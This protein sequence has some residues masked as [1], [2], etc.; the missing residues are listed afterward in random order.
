M[1]IRTQ[2][3]LSMLLF[4]VVLAGI[5]AS[6][7]VT[8]QRV[9]ESNE[10]ESLANNVAQGASE[11]SFL[12]NDYLIYR[13]D[14]QLGRWQNRFASFSADVAGL[15][16][17]QPE[18][19]SL[20]ADI[21]ANT[22]RLQ[23]VFD[24]VVNGAGATAQVQGG[25]VDLT[26]L[27]VSWSRLAVQSQGLISDASRLAQL[28]GA[29]ADQT[30][31]TNL[32]VIL[33]MIGLFGA[34][35]IVNYLLVQ[36][37]T[38]NSISALRAWSSVIGAGN[39]DLKIEEKKND[40]IG[41]LS[42]AFN[43]MT[44]SLKEVTASKAELE[45]EVAAR[46]ES[47]AKANALIKYAPT[48][49]YEI[50]YSGPRF[51]SVNDAVCSLTGFSREELFAMGP[52]ALLDEDSRKLFAERIRRQ[53]GGEQIDESVEY[54]IRKKDG[55]VILITLN[56]SFSKDKPHT[57]LV[58]G[59]DVTERRKV[60][61]AL[62]ESEEK[63]RQLYS[64]MNDGMA[65]HE[66]L[67]DEFGK[68]ID[69]RILDVNPMYE[70]ITGLSK[71]QAAGKK[72]TDLYGTK[73]P[74]YLEIYAATASSGSALS[75]ETYF[76]PMD[77]Y[78][79]ISVFSPKPGTFATIFSDVSQRKRAEQA[80][81]RYA[82]E[83]EAANHDLVA[84]NKELESFSYSVSHDLRTPLRSMDGYSKALLEDYASALDEQ[85]KKWLNNIRDSSQH[86]GRLIDDILG[87]SR[88]IRTE[89][90]MEKVDLSSLAFSLAQKLKEEDP[91]RGVE[92]VI[93]PGVAAKGDSNL[94][95]LSLQNLM[96]NAFKFT[97]GHVTAHIEFGVT[98]VDGHDVYFVKDDGVG[99]DMKYA[100]KL[101][102]PFQ[103]LH[104][105]KEYPGTGIG[106]VTVQRIIQRHGGK[107]WTESEVN[108]GATFFFTLGQERN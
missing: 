11:L 40:E 26:L 19:Q 20:A 95:T 4:G 94:L 81:E 83:L 96:G 78:F 102:K 47:E 106:L 57:A 36:R 23:D 55:S 69:Y 5:S 56:I 70:S 92:F 15:E 18:E 104:N 13:E 60:E 50:D 85:A 39:L 46:K 63:F 77:K 75:F 8:N 79:R 6:A 30:Q 24:S 58:I 82:D 101:F 71:E 66:I 33:A 27:Q 31:R 68:A 21:Q 108:K 87:L 17:D 32:F 12:A 67:F 103:R 49:I 88:V 16:T 2:F 28:Q 76:P 48:G 72:A 34:Y 43:Q 73:E 14:Q 89:L 65:L 54:K 45:K 86:M 105:E 9:E 1:R 10:Q 64:S 53:L 37:R 52:M 91:E 35:I 99:F 59:H 100:D 44:S 80:V 62:R 41:D 98:R 38:L 42:R 29:Q 7:V 22:Q 61:N 51:V 97:S 90:R 74:P 93:A 3:M 84:A 25:M 107:I